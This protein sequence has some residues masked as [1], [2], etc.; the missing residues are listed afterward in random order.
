MKFPDKYKLWV[1]H[2]LAKYRLYLYAKL[3]EADYEEVWSFIEDNYILKYKRLLRIEFDYGS[4]G[5]W[6]IPF[7]ASVSS[8]CMLH[9][10]NFGISPAL[11]KELQSWV[12]Y[13]DSFYD[14]LPAPAGMTPDIKSET[15]G[16]EIAKK[17]K[18][19]IG[20]DYYLEFNPF[21]ELIILNGDAV[22][23]PIPPLIKRYAKTDEEMEKELSDPSPRKKLSSAPQIK[24]MADYGLNSYDWEHEGESFDLYGFFE[25]HPETE[26]LKKE[27]EEWW[28]R[29]DRD[30]RD[31]DSDFPW[32][33]FHRKGVELAT[34]LAIVLKPSGV[35]VY[36]DR[37]FEDPKGKESKPF[38]IEV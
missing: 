32:E 16:L 19:E 21:K 7:P 33:E 1:S 3:N 25:V 23:R 8:P 36:Y 29:F 12:D 24:I 6:E 35:E 34:K 5:L 10:E 13:I 37:P 38:K 2:D 31:N 17:I 9:P 22:E 20:N 11:A 15:W 14:S 30:T 4:S 28:A 27:L 26:S 18:A